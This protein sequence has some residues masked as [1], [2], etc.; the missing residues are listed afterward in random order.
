MKDITIRS[1]TSRNRPTNMS[2]NSLCCSSTILFQLATDDGIYFIHVKNSTRYFPSLP[3][4][5]AFSRNLFT[6]MRVGS[7]VDATIGWSYTTDST[8][9]ADAL[10]RGLTKAL[11]KDRLNPPKQFH[12]QV[13]RV[14]QYA[15]NQPD[16]F[17]CM[18]GIKLGH[19]RLAE[20][21]VTSAT[22]FPVTVLVVSGASKTEGLNPRIIVL[23]RNH[24]NSTTED[25]APH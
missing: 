1:L 2:V 9:D 5:T 15:I 3:Y 7:L 21:L 23:H 20:C 25:L 8:V 11:P 18:K 19:T 14:L 10:H 12:I 4:S 24:R 17:L 6:L 13:V 16:S 22:H